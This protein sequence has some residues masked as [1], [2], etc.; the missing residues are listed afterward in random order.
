MSDKDE[1]IV[2]E[3]GAEARADVVAE[4]A[5]E[6]AA[7]GAGEAKVDAAAE[8]TVDSAGEKKPEKKKGGLL[9]IIIV[10]IV[11]VAVF[12]TAHFTGLLE[13]LDLENIAAVREEIQAY[14]FIV[15]PIFLVVYILVAVF[16]IPA[17]FFTILAGAAFG[18][19]WGPILSLVGATIGATVAFI[20]AR[21]VARG[22]IVDRFGDSP[23]FKKIDNGLRENGVS[24]LILTRLVPIFPYNVQNYI[25]GLTPI[26]LVTFSFVSLITMAPGAVLYSLLADR[27]LAEGLS[28]ILAVYFAG[29]GVILFL[30]SLIPK[31]IAKKKGIKLKDD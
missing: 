12:L 7:D 8:S 31:Y 4:A 15:Y 11:I 5:A 23:L 21:Y 22:M 2:E 24:F 20:I 25:Y 17:F 6:S 16:M 27:I 30:V 14:G 28:P 26:K 18:P 9:K 29:A 10:I 1:K 3:T 19:I 13:Y